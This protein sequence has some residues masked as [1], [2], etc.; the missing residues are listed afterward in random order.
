MRS[1]PCLDRDFD[2]HR[3]VIHLTDRRE[4]ASSKYSWGDHRSEPL[5]HAAAGAEKSYRSTEIIFIRYDALLAYNRPFLRPS[6]SGG[7]H[8]AYSTELGRGL[9]GVSAL[10]RVVTI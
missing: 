9:K 5:P 4:A 6:Q 2:A 1:L 3:R 10:C 7:P 8:V